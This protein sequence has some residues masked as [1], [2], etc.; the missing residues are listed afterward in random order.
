MRYGISRWTTAA[1]L[2]GLVNIVACGGGETTQRPSALTPT[3]IPEPTPTPTP[4]PTPTP[5]PTPCAACEVPVTNANPAARLTLRLY[6]V[7][8]PYGEPK[9]DFDPER[10]IPVDWVGRLDVVARDSEGY[11]TN[12]QGDIKFFFSNTK[13]VKVSGGHTHQRRLTVLAPGELTCW[14]TQDGVRSNDL[15]LQL[16]P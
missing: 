5:T 8:T 6:S 3:P 11:E 15:V 12:G 7:E 13:L 10:G 16:V 2:A 9:F 14:V 1:L 4:V